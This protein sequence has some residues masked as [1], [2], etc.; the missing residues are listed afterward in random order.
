M[1]NTSNLIKFYYNGK[2]FTASEKLPW[3]ESVITQGNKI[4][5][6][7]SYYDAINFNPYFDEK[8]NLNGKLM[9]P[10]FTDS[11]LHLLL[12]GYTL[13]DINLN[14]VK[15]KKE[16]QNRIKV[17]LEKNDNTFY[18]GGGW[19]HSLFEGKVL[20][21]KKWIDEIINDRPVFLTRLD[22]H[23][24]IANSK[25]L[26]IAGISADSGNP[27]GGVID[28]DIITGEPTGILRDS[29]MALVL[30]ALPNRSKN[31]KEKALQAALEILKKNGITSVHD[32]SMKGDFE[33][34]EQFFEKGKLTCRIN[35]IP[36][37][38]EV[39]DFSTVKIDSKKYRYYLRRNCVKAFAD[40]SLGASTALFET[41]YLN[42]DNNC[43][44]ETEIFS[45]GKI[46]KVTEKAN[47]HNV[48][49]AI[50]AIGDKAVDNVLTLYQ[51]LNNG[52]E[53]KDRRA[54]IEHVQ[55]IK[56][57]HLK[58]FCNNNVIASMQPIHLFYD[59]DTI[60]SKL[61]ADRFAGSFAINS[62]INN[63]VK[64]IFGSDWPVAETNIM[65]GIR[66][67]VNRKVRGNQFPNGFYLS[68]SISVEDAVKCYT[69]NPAFASFEEKIKGSIE[70]GKLA[71]FVI[72]NKNIFKINKNE[73]VN[74]KI[75][76]TIFD[77]E[78]IYDADNEG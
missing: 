44:V 71:D 37:I 25:A 53:K 51:N 63:E 16:F 64:V 59:A 22:Y 57:N 15:S 33:I 46:N 48:Q 19:D 12:G 6:T 73:I 2:I 61:G 70:V 60:K 17:Y 10:G 77:G 66:V 41:P 47:K 75:E 50:H 78:I 74:V 42:E 11:H 34:Y 7:G 40:G 23:L 9:L 1:A 32:I 35:S 26:E 55:H 14:S 36:L 67:A 3:V 13:T 8:I 4:I 27:I 54:R 62:L 21:D 72:L 38:E 68:E 52:D 18:K 49:L 5:F 56:K 45:S 28:K 20:P 29:A 39:T 58:K 65:H 76:Q 69:I 24:G 43:G 31:E 30:N